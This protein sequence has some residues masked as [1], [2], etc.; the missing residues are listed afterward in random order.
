M[1]I[2]VLGATGIIGTAVADALA[3]RHEVIRASRKSELTVDIQDPKSVTALFEKIGAVDAVVSCA[4]EVGGGAFA[5]FDQLTD[6]QLQHA[7]R[8]LTNGV[9]LVRTCIGRVRDGGSITVTTGQ[10]ATRPLPGTSA[11]AMAAAGMEG[12]VRAAALEMPR[13]TRLNSV[14]PGWVKE[15]MVKFGMDSTPGMPAKT[16]AEFYVLVVE[17]NMN[18]TI[19]DP[20][21]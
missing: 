11:L 20:T 16:L 21:A 19:V 7:T 17:G 8:R 3:A 1:K 14:S 13:K 5:P 6:E 15:T 18:G 4:G 2:V 10:L 9:S 12:F